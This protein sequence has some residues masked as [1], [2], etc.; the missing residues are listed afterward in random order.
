MVV[1]SVNNIQ[2]PCRRQPS[3]DAAKRDD[4]QQCSQQRVV[5]HEVSA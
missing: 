3:L 5:V 1:C 2:N 4:R